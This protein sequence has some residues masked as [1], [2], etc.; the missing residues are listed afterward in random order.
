[1]IRVF[2][3]LF[4]LSGVKVKNLAISSSDSRER[5]FQFTI[6]QAA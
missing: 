5:H 6:A 3:Y 4:F 1:M 2:L